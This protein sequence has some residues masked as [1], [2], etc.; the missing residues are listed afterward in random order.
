VS[1]VVPFLGGGFDADRMLS[2]L[3]C[4]KL[5][6]DDELIVADNTDDGVVA[7]PVAGAARVVRATRERSSYHAR[8][9][10]AAAAANDWLLFMDAD[11][12]PEPDLL[13]AY[14]AAPIS[15]DCGAISGSIVGEAS[16]RSLLPRYA[17]SRHFLSASDGLLGREATPTGNLLARRSA[18]DA[19]GGFAEGI[20][21]AGDLDLARRLRAAG[22]T[23][24]HR[25]EALVR[26]RHREDLRGFF[27]MIARY[28]AGA[29]WL[30]ER[31]PGSSPRWRLIPGLAGAA[32]DIG[33]LG[34]QGQFEEARFRALDGLG[35]IAHNIGYATGNVAPAMAD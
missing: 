24:E 9:V 26:H 33:R 20:R 30:N 22:W 3:A 35:L 11:C 4:L 29:R 7:R 19:I 12:S 14:F 28:G 23:I 16:Q 34:C 31:Y 32:L 2:N 21:S 5:H 8:N 6:P 15:A 27:E 13:A 10:G 18:F 1:L 25:G 17:R